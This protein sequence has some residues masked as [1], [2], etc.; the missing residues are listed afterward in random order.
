MSPLLAR[1]LAMQGYGF[2]DISVRC[3]ISKRAAKEIVWAAERKRQKR[4]AQ[5]IADLHNAAVREERLKRKIG[6]VFEKV[7]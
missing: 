3:G 4:L 1:R 7:S 2:E 5:I 6:I